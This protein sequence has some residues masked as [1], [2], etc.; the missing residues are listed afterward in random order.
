MQFKIEI[1]V[2]DE[3]FEK[4]IETRTEIEEEKIPGINEFESPKFQQEYVRDSI[5]VLTGWSI[6]SIEEIKK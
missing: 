3:V 4:L 6:L 2:P 5:E 1:E